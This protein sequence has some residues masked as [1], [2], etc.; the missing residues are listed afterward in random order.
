MSVPR[1]DA[2]EWLKRRINA[3]KA[4]RGMSWAQIAEKVSGRDRKVSA[5]SL[6]SKHSRASFTALELIE[7]LQALDVQALNLP[8]ER[9]SSRG[10][11]AR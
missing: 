10:N 6:M 2:A 5:G 8:A 4:E 7:I 11:P 9:G 3:A 1:T